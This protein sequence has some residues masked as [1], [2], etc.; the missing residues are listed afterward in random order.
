MNFALHAVGPSAPTPMTS[1][2]RSNGGKAR[3]RAR[4][5][6]KWSGVHSRIR[7]RFGSVATDCRVWVNRA[8][9]GR[10][11]GDYLPFQFD[12]TAAPA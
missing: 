8:A 11:G 6:K 3:R 9:V 12:I 10:H 2:S 7:L 4:L 1:A 5:P